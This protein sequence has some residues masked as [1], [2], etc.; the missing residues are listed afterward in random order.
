MMEARVLRECLDLAFQN[1]IT[2]P[3]TVR[4]LLAAGVECYHTDLVLLT[5][6]HYAAQGG[7]HTEPVPLRDP[8]AIPDRFAPDQVQAALVD[9]QQGKIDYPTFLRRIM[10]AGTASYDVFLNGKKTL[11]LGRHGDFYVEH[12]P[13][14]P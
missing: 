11:Y 12:F 4:R 10:A 13:G 5:K 1:R 9:I 2:F 14:A 6:T 3:E 8:P 7:T